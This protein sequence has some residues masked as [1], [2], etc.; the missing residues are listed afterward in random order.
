MARSHPA[1]ASAAPSALFPPLTTPAHPSLWPSQCPQASL[2]LPSA[3]PF[4]CPARP[5]ATRLTPICW[6]SYS[7]GGL[8]APRGYILPRRAAAGPGALPSRG[9]YSCTCLLHCRRPGKV[10]LK[11]SLGGRGGFCIG[12]CSDKVSWRAGWEGGPRGTRMQKGGW[13]KGH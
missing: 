10:P 3:Q 7:R 5:P 8:T 2:G 12:S 6:F 4:L 1:W 11:P 9:L 13:L